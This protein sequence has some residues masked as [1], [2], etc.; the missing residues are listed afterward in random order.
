[1]TTRI[2]TL[3]LLL[4]LVL[5]WAATGEGAFAQGHGYTPLD[6]ENG[7][8]LYQ[9]NCTGCHGPEG[10]GVPGIDLGRGTFRRATTDDEIVR[11]IIGGIPGTAMPPSSFSD[12]QAGTIVA[13]LR[14][15]VASPRGT[16]IP[17]DSTRGRA[18]V[19]G[20]GQ[21]LT[22]HSVAGAGAR[23]GPSLT[24]I[25][26]QRRAIELQRS[27]VEPSAQIR[28]DSQTV[29]AVTRQGAT[30]TGRLLNQDTFSLQ[31][32]DSTERLVHVEKSALREF[33]ILRES[34]MPSY[35]DRLSGQ[36]QADV[37]TYLMTLRGKR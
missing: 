20:K 34:P 8:L 22:C 32:L 9:A 13:Y 17:G 36:E 33:T 11:I 10:D 1:M 5:A 19:E 18:I 28:S 7:G 25:G 35:K 6:V 3:T 29:R 30:I 27:L 26:G 31:L 16:A 23:T 2:L 4:A 14:S 37:V 24:E 15:L 21:C 12:G